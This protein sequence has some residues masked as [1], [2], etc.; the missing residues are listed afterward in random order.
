VLF[1]VVPSPVV[2]FAGVQTFQRKAP[3]TVNFQGRS[4]ALFQ[5]ATTT[6]IS[7]GANVEND[8]EGEDDVLSNDQREGMSDAFAALDGLNADDFD[9]LRPPM[10][11][12]DSV[13]IKIDPILQAELSEGG[14]AVYDDILGDMSSDSLDMSYLDTGDED[15]TD[16][17]Q[18]L[19]KAA[20]PSVTSSV[21]ND[22]DGI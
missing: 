17:G 18:A 16:L 19:D 6:I 14:E 11:S 2:A 12:N 4:R 1:Q 15:V 3:A 8:N 9:D 21:L 5:P 7:L 22:A 13:P 10:V 20:T